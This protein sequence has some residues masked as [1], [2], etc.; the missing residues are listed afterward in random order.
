MGQKYKGPFITRPPVVTDNEDHQ[1]NNIQF[2]GV[3]VCSISQRWLDI[4]SCTFQ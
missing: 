3:F 1:N 4:I 2:R